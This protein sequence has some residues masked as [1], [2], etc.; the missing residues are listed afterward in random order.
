[1]VRDL[2]RGRQAIFNSTTAPDETQAMTLGERL[3]ITGL[4]LPGAASIGIQTPTN[5]AFRFLERASLSCATAIRCRHA[6]CTATGSTSNAEGL[7][8][9]SSRSGR[10]YPAGPSD[11]SPTVVVPSPALGE[12]AGTTG[13][14]SLELAPGASSAMPLASAARGDTDGVSGDG[15]YAKR[16][17]SARFFVCCLVIPVVGFRRN[18]KKFQPW[19]PHT[20]TPSLR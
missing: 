6:S 8:N 2:I 1:M 12:F 18:F 13:D 9:S 20:R 5:A 4:G 16:T 17:P 10:K 11:A 15:S 7:G 3:G 14:G 19:L